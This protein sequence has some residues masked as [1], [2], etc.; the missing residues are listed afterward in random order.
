MKRSIVLG[1]AASLAIAVCGLL[2][3]VSTARASVGHQTPVNN[4]AHTEHPNEGIDW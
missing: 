2:F 4:V 3:G 1:L